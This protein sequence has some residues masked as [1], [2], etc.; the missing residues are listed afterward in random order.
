MQCLQGHK[1]ESIVDFMILKLTKQFGSPYDSILVGCSNENSSLDSLCVD[2]S[3]TTHSSSVSG[4]P[5]ADSLSASGDPHS[6][7][8]LDLAGCNTDSSS[9]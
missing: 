5:N 6:D 1:S 2:G 3:N 8:M 7:A 4:S 9:A